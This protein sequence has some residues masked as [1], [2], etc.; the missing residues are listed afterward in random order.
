MNNNKTR[1]EFFWDFYKRW[2]GNPI[3]TDGY[4]AQCVSLFKI[5]LK[6]LGDPNWKRALGGDG[7]AH[8]ICYR[9]K[10][11]GYDKYF[12]MVSDNAQIGDVLVYKVTNETPYSHVSFFL[13]DVNPTQHY[14]WGQNQ[15]SWD[16]SS[17]TI[18]LSNYGIIAVLRPKGFEEKVINP[19][20]FSDVPADSYFSEAVLWAKEKG[21]IKGKTETTFDPSGKLTRA[22]LAVILHRYNGNPKP[23][24]ENIFT[25]ICHHEYYYESVLWTAEHNITQGT[26]MKFKPLDNT[27]RGQIVTMLYRMAGSPSVDTSTNPFDDVRADTYYFKP[28]IWAYQNKIATG[29]TPNRFDPDTAC[30]R[31]DTV[32]FLKRYDNMMGSKKTET[33]K[34]E[35]SLSLPAYG[36][37][38]SEHNGDI[39]LTPYKNQFVII[40]SS[41]W[42]TEDRYFRENIKKCEELGIPYGIYIYSYALNVDQAKTESQFAVDLLK[43]VGANPVC[44]VWIDIESDNFKVQN[45]WSF[46]KS[47]PITKVLC[48]TVKQAGYKTGIYAGVLTKDYMPTGYPL[49][50]AHYNVDDGD[51]HDDWSSICDIHQYTSKPCDKNYMY[52]YPFK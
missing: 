46:E 31:A 22:D 25:D 3:D 35:F 6:E 30:N 18:T 41:W 8:Q 38:I 9:F 44:G 15:G 7:Y 2:N 49:W 1:E 13:G 19:T 5:Y 23:T 34:E 36:I 24:I 47:S 29:K 43:E 33:K 27:T 32:V 20:G 51:R 4:G 10:E 48:E 28:V 11:L 39:D 52:R 45:G 50:L 40:R 14:S 26:G 12:D 42:T 21:I 17:N 16:M 37:D